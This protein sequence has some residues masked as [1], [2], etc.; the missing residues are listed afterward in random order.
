MFGVE[1]ELMCMAFTSKRLAFTGK[2]CARRLPQYVWR[3]TGHNGHGISLTC[4]AFKWN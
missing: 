3:L 2:L 1:P 4:S